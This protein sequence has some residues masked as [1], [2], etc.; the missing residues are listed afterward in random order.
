MHRSIFLILTLNCNKS[1]PFCFNSQYKLDKKE[2]F[3]SDRMEQVNIIFNQFE[4]HGFNELII[5]GGEPL[6]N[7][8]VLYKVIECAKKNNYSIGVDT[9]GTYLSRSVLEKLKS[10]GVDHLYISSID[11]INNHEKIKEIIGK[12]EIKTT[13]IH[14]ITKENLQKTQAVVNLANKH[15]IDLILQPAFVK[16]D[17]KIFQKLSLKKLNKNQKDFFFEIFK[18]WA[19]NNRKKYF[20]VVKG[21]Y[22]NNKTYFPKS[23]HLGVD[24]IILHPDGDAFSCFHR[25]DLKCGNIFKDSADEIIRKMKDNS[26]FTDRASCFGEHCLSNFINY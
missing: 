14:V 25:L 23:C 16:D 19:N 5:T 26:K 10:F 2:C 1:C 22:N 17:L 13:I 7:K 15:G 21:Y 4:S 8:E 3:T 12:Y 20:E 11:F 9:N 6:I 24:D 18:N